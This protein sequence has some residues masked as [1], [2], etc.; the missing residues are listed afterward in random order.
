M[1]QFETE[2][3][4]FN[5]NKHSKAE[6]D[7]EEIAACQEACFQYICNVLKVK[8]EFKIEYILCDTPEEV[9]QAYGDTEPCNGFTLLP[10]T[11]YAVYNDHI[12]CIGFH[13]DAH[14][15]SYTINRPDS[16][17]IREGLA[18]YFDRKWWGIQNMDWTGYYL[19]GNLYLPVDKL[20]DKETFFDADC[21][22]TYPIMGAFTD[23]LI[24]TYGIEAYMAFYRQQDVALAMEKVF[25]KTPEEL[26]HDFVS[27][28]N[29]FRLDAVVE[30]RIASLLENYEN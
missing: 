30:E 11:I 25:H 18:M 2:H 3:Y 22:V 29:L 12:Q 14:V 28:M 27:Y 21:S 17:A 8:P 23:Y 16:P 24:S 1:K 5:Y 10:N 20:L 6:A 4:I 15:I 26:N 19:K 13:K 9:G 7:I